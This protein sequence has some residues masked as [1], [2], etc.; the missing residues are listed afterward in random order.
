MTHDKAEEE[1]IPRPPDSANR[2][3]QEPDG[4]AGPTYHQVRTRKVPKSTRPPLSPTA[5]PP[6]GCSQETS[7]NG[8]SIF[9]LP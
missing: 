7:S 3:G 8:T 6:R 2:I 9:T 1:G 5:Y 4:N